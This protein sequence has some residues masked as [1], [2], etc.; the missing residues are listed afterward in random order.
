MAKD[1]GLSEV[2]EQLKEN[3][4]TNEE[5]SKGFKQWMKAQSKDKLKNLESKLEQS[6]GGRGALAVGR[7]IGKVGGAAS[8]G[9]GMFGSLLTGIGALVAPLLKPLKAVFKLLGKGGPIGLFIA[10]M[11]TLFKDIG[12]NE[13]FKSTMESIKT[14][15]NDRILPTFNSIK[16][17]VSK[18]M[19]NEGVQE[20]FEKIG[21]WFSNFKTQIQDWVLVNLDIITNTIAG[22]LEGID[23]LINGEWM[24]GL[25][26]IGSSLFGG[27]KDFLD[28]SLTNFLELFGLDFG[29]DGTLFNFLGRKITEIK[30]S[31]VD[32]WKGFVSGVTDAWS[33]MTNFF[34]GE[35]GYV[36]TTITGIKTSIST[37]WDSFK[38]TITDGWNS[39][40][41]F[42]TDPAQEGS[43]PYHFNNIKTAISDKWTSMVNVITVDF[44]NKLIEIKDS[45]FEKVGNIGSEYIVKP[46]TDAIDWIKDKFNVAGMV[47][48]NLKDLVVEKWDNI[49]TKIGAAFDGIVTWFSFVPAKIKLFLDEKWTAIKY[50]LQEGFVNFGAWAAN[51][52]NSI[53]VAALKSI[54][55]TLGADSRLARWFGINA[56]LEAAQSRSGKFEGIADQARASIAASKAADLQELQVRREQLARD[57]A[58][59]MN[60]GTNVVIQENKGGD[61][62][63]TTTLNATQPSAADPYSNAYMD[64]AVQGLGL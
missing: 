13:N 33:T 55:S 42:F 56:A 59:A 14:T 21:N 37:K 50:D 6:R 28:N 52:P 30:D 5:T 17:T 16:E 43:I 35:D 20:T 26:T 23:L 45:I 1:T 63:S 46:V 25:K 54:Q 19:E 40:I 15:W 49:T 48:F 47:A 31:M 64:R 34:T 18:L 12:E 8:A 39:M 11:Y 7:G 24:E 36:Q 27:I 38:T 58:A 53:L 29:E 61:T 22:V 60:G 3:N 4:E 41:S 44:P 10:G 57:E 51:L 32:K 2:V 62:V 9:F